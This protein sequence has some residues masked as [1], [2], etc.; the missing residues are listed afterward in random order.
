[1]AT[2]G[3]RH[4][5]DGRDAADILLALVDYPKTAEHPEFTLTLKVN[6]ADGSGGGEEGFRFVGSDGVMN[7]G[8]DSVTL[9]RRAPTKEPGHSI[10][11]FPRA[12]QDAYLEEYRA[13]YPGGDREMRASRDEIFRNPPEYSDTDHHL[14][15]FIAAVRTR[16]PVVEDP[17]FGLRAAGPA[18]LCNLSLAERRPVGWDPV[19]MRV[20]DIPRG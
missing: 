20:V 4:W 16:T 14:A 2:G 13:K 5:K 19:G 1:M 10:G 9:S 11:T 7:L 17:A 12:M 15:N 8:R 18:L 6:F 3:L